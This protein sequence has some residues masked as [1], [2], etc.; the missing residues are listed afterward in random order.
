MVFSKKD[1]KT[2]MEPKSN[3]VTTTFMAIWLMMIGLVMV[4]TA[5]GPVSAQTA[6]APVVVVNDDV[7]TYYDVDQ[8]ARLMQLNGA[9][10]GAQLNSAALEALID[11][12]LR[13]QAG[14]RFQMETSEEEM[15]QAVD[16]FAQRLGVDRQTAMAQIDRLGVDNQT[17]VDFLRAQVIWRELVTRRFGNRST[18]SELELDQEIALAASGKTRSFRLS[19]IALPTGQGQEAQA[20][21][22]MSRILNELDGGASFESLARRYSQTPSAPNGGD[23]GWVPLTTLPAQ[24]GELIAQ[25]PPGTVTEPFAVPGGL[26]IYRVADTR[27]ESPPW[28]RNAQ[29]SLRRFSVEGDSDA[30]MAEVEALRSEMNG[31]ESIPDLSEQATMESLDNKLVSAL[32]GPVR[33]AVELLQAGQSSRPL[34]NEGRVEIFVVCDRSGGVDDQARAQLR[35]QIRSVRLGRFSD[36]FLQDL[37]RDAV[38]ERR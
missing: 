30:A 22:L 25:T 19:E 7:I 15:A 20:R 28:A 16:E 9:T 21:Q 5:P 14:Q 10:P 1:G 24:L 33:G 4:G 3:R 38:I 27:E 23:V 11:D 29:V 13:I 35:D 6:F 8:R 2:K 26:S 31:C 12:R 18:P 32:P 36:G 34:R 37:R 17:L